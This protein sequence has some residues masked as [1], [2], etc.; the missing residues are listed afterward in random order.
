MC[1]DEGGSA[2]IWAQRWG[3]ATRGMSGWGY[4]RV[5]LCQ[6]GVRVGSVHDGKGFGLGRVISGRGWGW[7]V[8]CREGVWDYIVK[9]F[10]LGQGMSGWG[11]WNVVCRE[12]LWVGYGYLGIETGWELGRR[13]EDRVGSSAND[14]V[15]S[16]DE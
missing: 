13:D 11:S 5:G 1:K 6:E 10:G 2:R 3:T 16:R 7:D 15:G 4:G 14:G 9:V 8:V 12:G